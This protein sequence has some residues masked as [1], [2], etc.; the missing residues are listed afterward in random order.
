M[1]IFLGTIIFNTGTNY[2]KYAQK[3]E[4]PLEG[5]WLN[6][7]GRLVNAFFEKENSL[8]FNK[9]YILMLLGKIRTKIV[10]NWNK[11][12]GDCSFKMNFYKKTVCWTMNEKNGAA[13]LGG[14]ASDKMIKIYFIGLSSLVWTISFKKSVKILNL[15]SFYIWTKNLKAFMK[16]WLV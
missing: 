4:I 1:T 6:R 11:I 5:S 2:R 9:Y 3:S 15:S 10:G 8:K 13:S 14:K 7:I 12:S 16:T